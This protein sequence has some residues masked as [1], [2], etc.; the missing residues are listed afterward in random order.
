MLYMDTI[1]IFSE[2]YRTHINI[3]SEILKNFLMLK[4]VVYKVTTKL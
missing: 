4:M 1:G 3:P 2:R